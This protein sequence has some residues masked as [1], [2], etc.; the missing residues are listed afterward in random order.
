MQGRPGRFSLIGVK[1]AMLRRY[2]IPLCAGLALLCLVRAQPDDDFR[3]NYSKREYH[4]PMRDGKKLFTAVYTPRDASLS[5]P[6]LLTRTPYSVSP[7]GEDNFPFGAGPSDELA[8][9]GFIFACQDV[10]GTMM[11]EGDFVNMTPHKPVKKGP[12]DVDES[13]DAYDTI[14]WLVKNVPNNNG[15]VGMWGI[16]YPGF[17]AAAGMIDAHPALK[18]VSPQAPIADWFVGDDFHHNGAFYLAHAF[19]FLS[20]FGYPRPKPTTRFNP[21]F[22]FPTPDGYDFYLKMGP[23]SGANEKYLKNRVPFW[24]EVLRHGDYDEFW[25]ARNLLPHLKNIRPAVLT[26]GGWFDA[27]DLYGTLEV[28][29]SVEA[30]S[31]GAYNVLVMGPWYHG[32]WARSGGDTFGNLR[33]GSDTSVFYRRE[34]EFP[35][36]VHFLKGTGGLDLPE[37]YV[38]MTGLNRWERMDAWPPRDARPERLYL[39]AE[40]GLSWTREPEDPAAAYDEYISDP[41]RPVPYTTEITTAMT[42]EHMVDDQRFASRRPDVLTYATE[43]LKRDI[44]IAGPVSPHLSVSTSGTDADFIVKLIDVHPDDSPELMVSRENI[45][46]GGFQQLV[47]AEPFRGKYRNSFSNPEPFVPGEVA[48]LE[49][50]MPDVFHTFRKG[51]RIMVQIQSSWFP[52]IDRNPQQFLDIYRAKPADFIKATHRVHRSRQHPSYLTIHKLE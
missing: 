14:D 50:G 38:F 15:N 33:F 6:I 37:A 4:I 35:F 28:Y 23:L 43:T 19:G 26:V 3:S 17:Y 49:F 21:L 12:R 22:E 13:T 25:Q 20:N 1:T 10:R 27:E 16:S 29:R 45:R 18:A 31:P 36:F 44:T 42:R 39:G 8:R 32:A 47:R 2:G 24:N 34:I 51:H 30:S 7:Y 41:A 46:M 9:D 40:E 52:L 11:S 48:V 5:Y